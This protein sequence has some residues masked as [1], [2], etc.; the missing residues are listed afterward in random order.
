MVRPL[1]EP[2]RWGRQRKAPSRPRARG[3]WFSSGPSIPR[4]AP[5][6][7]GPTSGGGPARVPATGRDQNAWSGGTARPTVQRHGDN[8]RPP[9]RRSGL[10]HSAR[11]RSIRYMVENV[12]L[13][14]SS[15]RRRLP[16]IAAGLAR[17][18]AGAGFPL[19]PFSFALGK[20]T[21]RPFRRPL[22]DSRRGADSVQGTSMAGSCSCSSNRCL[23]RAS[24][25]L[26]C[27]HRDRV[28]PLETIVV[29]DATSRPRHLRGCIHCPSDSGGRPAP[30][31]CCACGRPSSTEGPPG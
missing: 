29:A 20:P 21:G 6:S 16:T 23:T 13:R 30:S 1:V 24:P 28:H 11:F 25:Q 15:C 2:G 26:N 8:Q 10:C 14:A 9:C 18:A 12:R 7:P 31:P 19:H 5:P 3:P 17:R 27:G 22:L 4:T